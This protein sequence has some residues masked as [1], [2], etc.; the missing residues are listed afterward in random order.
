MAKTSTIELH[1][2]KNHGWDEVAYELGLSEKQKNKFFEYGEYASISIE[3]D[4][5][6]NIIGGKI[7]EL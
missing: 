4:E 5:N 6:M 7:F 2:I 3:I 1:D